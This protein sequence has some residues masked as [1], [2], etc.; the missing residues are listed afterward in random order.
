MAKDRS[1][2][3]TGTAVSTVTSKSRA[4]FAS[5]L[6]ALGATPPEAGKH[7][8]QLRAKLVYFFTRRCLQ[9][10]EDLADEVLDRLGHRLSEGLVISSV[11]AFALG[12]ARHVAQEQSAIRSPVQAVDPSFFDNISAVS[13]TSNEDER[14][15]VLQRC[16]R[17]LPSFDTRLLK[18][19]YLDNAGSSMSVR[20]NM[21]ERLG[22]S[23]V[24]LRQRVFLIRR[25]L[26]ACVTASLEK[27]K[28]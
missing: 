3:D 13:A 26:V 21:A 19:Y 8:E 23:S 10:P 22:M 14:L 25:R 28:R 15:A 18:G 7:Y 20:K 17:R 16:L 5:L 6:A 2:P 27:R 12:V 9:S 1:I 11:D 4:G 24:T